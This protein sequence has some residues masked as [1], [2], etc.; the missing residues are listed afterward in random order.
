[1]VPGGL[2]PFF[3]MH[4]HPGKR[5][6]GA[7]WEEESQYP[8]WGPRGPGPVK[9]AQVWELIEG[10]YLCFGDSSQASVHSA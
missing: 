6:L 2:S 5:L 9:L 8:F 7:G 3:L 4:S 1:M 10:P